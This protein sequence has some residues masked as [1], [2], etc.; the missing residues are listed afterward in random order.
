MKIPFQMP[1]IFI[2][3]VFFKS[4]KFQVVRMC[5]YIILSRGH[6][7]KTKGHH[8]IKLKQYCK[9]GIS[10]WT[11]P[12]GLLVYRY[13]HRGYHT[14]SRIAQQRA[15]ASHYCRNFSLEDPSLVDPGVELTWGWAGLST[16][17]LPKD[18]RQRW[19]LVLF[20]VESGIRPI[21]ELLAQQSPVWVGRK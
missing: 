1:V 9:D 18:E 2:T 7:V 12:G 17:F 19:D 15:A 11:A 8:Y 3:R 10:K 5:M 6:I 4:I 21:A 20:L 14:L 13:K 16:V